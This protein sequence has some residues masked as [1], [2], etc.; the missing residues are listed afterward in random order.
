MT[1]QQRG[2]FLKPRR[3]KTVLER[4]ET[5]TSHMRN[6]QQD[7]SDTYQM[8]SSGADRCYYR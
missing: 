6:V 8:D 2:A 1:D 5:L 4:A 7:M 3:G